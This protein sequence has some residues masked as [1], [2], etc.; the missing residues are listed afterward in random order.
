MDAENLI[1]NG[2]PT[3]EAAVI[4]STWNMVYP[5]IRQSLNECVRTGTS[6]GADMSRIKELR[7][8]LGQLDRCTH[9]SCTQSPRGFSAWAAL[10]LVQDIIRLLPDHIVG[11]THRLA[12]VLADRALVQR[13]L[14][15]A[16]RYANRTARS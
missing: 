7:R 13:T 6:Q 9:R 12:A 14:L 10:F 3:E 11:D 1:T 5:A 8:E 4:A 2:I 15:Q 16:E